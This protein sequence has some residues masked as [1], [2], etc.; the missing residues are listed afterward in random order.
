MIENLQEF[1]H[2]REVLIRAMVQETNEFVFKSLH[3][4]EDNDYKKNIILDIL[5][6]TYFSHIHRDLKKED[7]EKYYL[8]L[9]EDLRE[10]FKKNDDFIKNEES[11]E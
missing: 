10:V 11:N 9:I 3:F 2:Y 5:F 7:R 1:V 6:N 4:L 8:V